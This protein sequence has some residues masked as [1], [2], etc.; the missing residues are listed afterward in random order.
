MEAVMFRNKKIGW[1]V[2]LW[3][4]VGLLIGSLYVHKV[5][6]RTDKTY[7][8]LRIF[9]EV[10]EI[11]QKNYVEDVK[12]EKLISGAIEGML[13]SL[14]PHSAYLTPDMYR[15]LQVETKGSFGGLGIE[16]AL[17]DGI[18]TVIAP[19]EDTPAYR[20][21]IKAGDKILKI[22]GESTKGMSLQASVNKLRGPKGTEVTI[23]IMREGFNQLKDFTIVRDVITIKSVKFKTLE[24]GYGYLR[25]MQFQEQTSTDVR[26]ALDEL[27]KENPQGIN[28]LVI[29]LRNNPGGLLD[30]AVDVSDVFLEHGVIVTI[31]G[32]GDHE[33]MVFNAHK[34]KTIPSWPLVVI[35]NQG[36]ASASEI[37]AG[38]LQDYGRAVILG[39]KTFGKGS[40]Q[41][42]IPLEDGSGIRLTTA[43]YYTPNGR[44]IQ[45]H[46]IEPDIPISI[47]D[48]SMGESKKEQ[49]VEKV[50]D[51]LLDR[52]LEHLK[53]LRIF[54]KFLKSPGK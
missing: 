30:Q 7:E 31:K 20:A 35:V 18:L 39:S 3:F 21:G 33:K 47:E 10:L 19:I 32:R 4:V 53:G 22:N 2:L 40:V 9:T 51:P 11:V 46:G 14:D 8:K 43:R 16:I 15:E 17:K 5:L 44:S 27:K 36:S 25:I 42:I 34:A 28:G 1:L 29:D 49:K 13:H 50:E 45:D 52:A 26:K 38:A 12:T 23:T 41:T 37:V 54:Q 48:V 24:K 6:A